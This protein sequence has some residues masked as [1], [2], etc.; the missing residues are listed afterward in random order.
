MPAPYDLQPATAAVTALLPGVQDADLDGPTPCAGMS[1]RRMLFHLL[2]LSTAF[3][4]AARKE[5]GPTTATP[6]E[7]VETNLPLDWRTALPA[8]LDE[9]AEAWAKPD[10]W[11]GMTQAG[12]VDLPGA[13]AGQVALNEVVIHGWDL[14]RAT[15]QPYALDDTT[16]QGSYDLMWPPDQQQREGMFGPVVD[17]PAGAPL[18]DRVVGLSGRNPGWAPPR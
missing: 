5:L 2:G 8:V 6:P 3:R 17:V 1:V 7:D 12:G 11:E 4:D 9:L 10:A 16:L 15:G 18:L 13:V 14:A